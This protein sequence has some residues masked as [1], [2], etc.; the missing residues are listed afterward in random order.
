VLSQRTVGR[1]QRVLTALFT[2]MFY[3]VNAPLDSGNYYNL[4]YQEGIP[5]KLLDYLGNKYSFLP[6]PITRALHEGE[7]IEIVG[8][9]LDSNY[10]L[11]VGSSWPIAA[12]YLGHA[13]WQD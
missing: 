11:P 2:A 9:Y 7:A 5:P 3:G 6:V 4:L 12:A 10:A 13:F 8:R 1:F